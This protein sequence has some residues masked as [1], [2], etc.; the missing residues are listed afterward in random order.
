MA[1]S[2]V[3]SKAIVGAMEGDVG[4][5]DTNFDVLV[6]PLSQIIDL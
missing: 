2:R 3:A 6:D 4:M 1:E 5:C